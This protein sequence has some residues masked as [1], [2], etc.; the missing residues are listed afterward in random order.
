MTGCTKKRYATE[1]QALDFLK[2]ARRSGRGKDVRTLGAYR[3]SECGGWHLGHARRTEREIAKMTRMTKAEFRHLKNLV[4]DIGR[5]IAKD[6]RRWIQR[7]FDELT[8]LVEADRR[9]GRIA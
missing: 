1:R 7:K 4:E 3:C 6:E 9:A 5:Q 2:I 8:W